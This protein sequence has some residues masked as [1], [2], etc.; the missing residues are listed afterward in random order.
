MPSYSRSAPDLL[1]KRLRELYEELAVTVP[2]VMQEIRMIEGLLKAT[3]AEPQLVYSSLTSP[4]DAIEMC[5]NLRGDFKL[6]KPEMIEEIL[7]GG[8][9]AAKPKTSRGLLN[10]S[11]NYRI[12]KGYL[13]VKNDL[14]GRKSHRP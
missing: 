6:T 4:S 10:D 3:G 7:N 5:L 12:R 9:L 14:V 8:Y 2:D 11:L 1:R 13:A